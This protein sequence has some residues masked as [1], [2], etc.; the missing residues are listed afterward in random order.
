LRYTS[1]IT[2]ERFF[3]TTEI[4]MVCVIG[5]GSLMSIHL[6]RALELNS[7]TLDTTGSS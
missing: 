6:Q 1:L 5:T 2:L 3:L 7:T 4:F